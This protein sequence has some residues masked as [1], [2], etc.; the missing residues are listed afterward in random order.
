MR[1]LPKFRPITMRYTGGQTLR[2]RLDGDQESRIMEPTNESANPEL[3]RISRTWHVQDGPND[4]RIQV[5]V[6]RRP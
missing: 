1:R 5:Q 4:Y 6:T 2:C 3:H